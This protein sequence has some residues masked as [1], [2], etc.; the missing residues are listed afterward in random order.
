MIKLDAIN[1][2]TI[3]IMLLTVVIIAATD[4]GVL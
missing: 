2:L 3:V 4:L 1:K